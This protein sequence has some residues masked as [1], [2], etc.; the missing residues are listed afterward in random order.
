MTLGVAVV[1]LGVGEQHA[2]AFAA[3]DRCR[4]RSVCD[5]DVARAEALAGTLGAGTV[6][7]SFEDVL[8][9]PAIDVVSLASYDDAH[10]AQVVAAFGARKHV[11]VEKPLCRSFEELAVIR[12]AWQESSKHLASNLVLRAAPLYRWLGDAITA[13]ELGD[14]YA[15]DGE[16]LY[17]RVEKITL[18]WRNAVE[19]YS[20]M[21]GGGVHL[22]DLMIGLTGQFPTGVSAVGSRVATA[23]TA[24]RY[25]DYR[26]A[27]FTFA[28]G[29][30]GRIAANFGCVH[31]HQHVVR[32]FGTKATF[33]YDDAGPRLHLSRDPSHAPMRVDRSPLPASKGD[34]I[35]D[36]VRAI[37]DGDDPAPAAEREFAVI[38]ACLAADRAAAAGTA[39]SM[40]CLS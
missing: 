30:V 11:F 5:L 14:V 9:D 2:R 27:T 6:A 40:D 32:V 7:S 36:F 19:N 35:P 23:G 20:V 17:G 16:Y 25:D 21:Q 10:F 8:A 1:G 28:S 26:A 37:D 12:Q 33:L 39:V 18:G 31:R 15:F 24:F 4:L 34:L 29:L 22:V 13:G 38:R 3:I